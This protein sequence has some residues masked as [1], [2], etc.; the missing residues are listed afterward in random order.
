MH[1]A[2]QSTYLSV[3]CP[4]SSAVTLVLNMHTC[5]TLIDVLETAVSIRIPPLLMCSFLWEKQVNV[6]NCTQL[7]WSELQR[8]THTS[9][10][11]LLPQVTVL[12]VTSGVTTCLRFERTLFPPLQNHSPVAFLPT[13]PPQK[14]GGLQGRVPYLLLYLCVSWPHH[15]CKTG[16]LL[17]LGY[18]LIF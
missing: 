6:E 18:Y 8:N 11:H 10:T 13:R 15:I 7:N 2:V 1:G 12:W 4:V 14:S 16:L 5:F 3:L 17:L 9:D